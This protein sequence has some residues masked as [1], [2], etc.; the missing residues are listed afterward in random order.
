MSHSIA[1][2]FQFEQQLRRAQDATQLG[3]TIVNQLNLCLPLS[4]AVLLLGQQRHNLTISAVSDLPVVDHTAPYISWVKQLSHQLL[5]AANTQQI[6]SHQTNRT[7]PESQAQ[8][9]SIAGMQSQNSELAQQWAEMAPAH[10]LLQ[11]VT[12]DARDGALQGYLLLFRDEAFS[13]NEQGILQHLGRSIGHALFAM[14]PRAS[15]GQWLKKIATKRNSLIAVAALAVISCI[16]VRM[17]TLAPIS[18]IPDEPK[19]VTAAIDG[20]IKR[21]FV[22][23]NQHVNADTLLASMDDTELNAQY[24]V[25]QQ[26]QL[27]AAAKLKTAQQSG[28]MDPR[29]NAQLAQLMAE[30]QLKSAEAAYAKT[31]FERAKIHAGSRGV[32]VLNDPE[33]WKGQPVK[34]GQRI[35]LIADPAKVKV[36]AMLPVKSAIA[37]QTGAK[38]KVFLDSDPLHSWNA[39]L[40]HAS[41][42]PETGNDG[43]VAYRLI[44]TLDD[45]PE[46]TPRIGLAG[47]ARIYGEQV[48]L[49]F[50]L[51]HRPIT[52]LRQWL[53]W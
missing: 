28:F 47:V 20:V 23:P 31:R 3:Y 25:A 13:S 33:R 43:Q 32:I 4:Q 34:V 16:P 10:L 40:A 21:I 1:D 15:A 29:Q 39:S 14:R 17:S 53:G 6:A 9:L 46:L 27:V 35:M 7:Q 19:V 50:Y 2:L 38:M 22:A 41:Y 8:T 26:A 24:Q 5:S 18:I 37:L 36:Q 30:L 48:S 11:P 45:N 42:E 44:A 49:F 52:A 51:F 12:V